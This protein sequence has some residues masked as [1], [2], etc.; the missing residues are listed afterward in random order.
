MKIYVIGSSHVNRFSIS[1]GDLGL[2][3]HDIRMTGISGGH[4]NDLYSLIPDIDLFKPDALFLQIGSNDISHYRKPAF[5]VAYDIRQF[6]SILLVPIKV[7]GMNFHR[8]KLRSN[9]LSID[10]YNYK[11]ACLNGILLNMSLNS[12]EFIFWRH[13]GLQIS[14]YDILGVD[15]VHLNELG[16]YR[17]YRSLRGFVMFI[18]KS[19]HG[20]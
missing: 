16:S 14:K 20:Y 10:A 6:L 15:G 1:C 18:D 3:Q 11:V 5:R 19:K 9:H 2:P 4:T 17:L 7:V 13:K 8:L 12:K